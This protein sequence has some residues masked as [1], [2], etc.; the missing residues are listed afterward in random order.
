MTTSGDPGR[1]LKAARERLGLKYREVQDA[2]SAL[3]RVY[4]N[5][6]FSIGLSRLA[7]IENHGT[8]PSVFRIYSL[9]AV[10]GLSIELVFSWYGIN[11]A[12]LPRDTLK[13]QHRRTRLVD[14]GP[15]AARSKK[16]CTAP[17]P[18]HAAEHPPEAPP[19]PAAHAVLHPTRRYVV[20]GT[21]D[22]SMYPLIYPGAFVQF[23]EKRTKPEKGPWPQEGDRPIYVIETRQ[24]YCCAWCSQ[25]GQEIVLQFH[26]SSGLEPQILSVPREGEILGRVIGVAMRV[27]PARRRRKDS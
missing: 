18:V 20:V 17:V 10:Y 2:T 19:Q 8:V 9:C 3:A 27:D 21:E 7:D 11:L 15:A 4:A 23:D 1:R 6:E 12:K 24:G 22:W 16:P 5:E 26:P 13:I 14:Q 25:R